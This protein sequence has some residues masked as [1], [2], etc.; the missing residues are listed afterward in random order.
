MNSM[1]PLPAPKINPNFQRSNPNTH[2][3]NIWLLGLGI[4]G[5]GILSAC[6]PSTRPVI[7]IGL[8][9]PF[10]GRY[11]EIGEEIVYAVRLAV[12]EAN[13]AGGVRG[14]SI[15]LMAF[16]DGG[17]PDQA[18]EQ[19]RKLGTDPGVVGVIGDWLE[20]TTLTAAP[21]FAGAGTP[22]LATTASPDL[23]PSAFRLWYSESDYAFAVSP[24]A[25]CPLPCEPAENLDWLKAHANGDFPV[26]GPAIWG[27]NQFVRLAGEAAEGVNVVAPAPLPADSTDPSFAERY[28]ALSPGPEPRF[29]AVL[30]Y[31][32]AQL[33][34]KAIEHD[35]K[36]N[37]LPTRKGVGT[38]LLQSDYFGLSGHFSFDSN[39]DW[40]EGKGWVYQWREGKIIGP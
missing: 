4:L 26:I 30:A 22:F 2:T 17:D 37:G 9:A 1:W 7:K 35:A 11:R 15:E 8:V 10:E 40:V 14:Y 13:Q 12:R 23:E 32:T 19:A 27:L 25:A 24:A 39:R 20:A 16:D 36:L 6:V 29:L 28:R 38:A 5:F 31:D 21:V 34:F 33:L 3:L 18:E